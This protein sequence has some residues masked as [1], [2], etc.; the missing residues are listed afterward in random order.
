MRR[1]RG[2]ADAPPCPAHLL[3][4]RRRP[5]AGLLAR[6]IYTDAG[7]LLPPFGA[8]VVFFT[9]CGVRDLRRNWPAFRNEMRQRSAESAHR[10]PPTTPTDPCPALSPVRREPA[11]AG[12]QQPAN[13]PRSPACVTSSTSSITTRPA[14]RGQP[15]RRRTRT[16][17]RAVHR[18]RP[19]G[20]PRLLR[21]RSRTLGTP[22]RAQRAPPTARTCRHEQRQQ[23]PGG[24]AAR[25]EG[26]AGGSGGAARFEEW[27]RTERLPLAR[28]KL[29]GYAFEVTARAWRAW[30]YLSA[31]PSRV[32][33]GCAAVLVD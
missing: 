31:Q 10:C 16:A 9:W 6:A 29:G 7:S 8:G 30:Q 33:R 26:E 4:R 27:A 2:I 17:R 1:S 23:G 11:P 28:G 19:A 25:S 32:I 3:R 20:T 21:G 15:R 14:W 12:F 24:R 18:H 22:R 5:A 13:H